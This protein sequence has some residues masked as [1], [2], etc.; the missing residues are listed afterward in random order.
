MANT[1][2]DYTATAGQTDFNFSFPYLQDDH[3][4]VLKDG[5]EETG[6]TIALSPTRI[7][8]NVAA[9]GGE[10]IRIRRS[11]DPTV[12]LVDFENG[13]VLTENELDLAYRHNRYLNEEAYEGNQS[14]LQTVEGSTNFDANF[15]KIVNLAPPT[16]S[17]DAANKDYVD[18][19]LVLSGTSLSGFN[20]SVHTGDNTTTQFTLSF[21]AQT[22]T[23]TAFR[24]TVNGS[25]QTP[26]S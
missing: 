14:S 7:V 1:Y 11:S 2:V 9:T 18:D 12:N 21:T 16:D 24:V 17:T 8:L 22:G 20:K 13:S 3:V 15:N 19:K 26:R 23:A 25:V 10:A 5:T 6:F 4:E